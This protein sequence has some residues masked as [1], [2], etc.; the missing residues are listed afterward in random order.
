MLTL[1][2]KHNALMPDQQDDLNNSLKEL[3]ATKTDEEL[4][5]YLIDIKEYS[6]SEVRAALAEQ[7]KR[8]KHYNELQL[9]YLH[10]IIKRKAADESSDTPTYYSQL[11]ILLFSV[12][13]STLYGSILLALNVKNNRDKWIIIGFGLTYSILVITLANTLEL[14]PM[15]PISLNT[16]GGFMLQ[17]LFWDRYLDKDVL[18]KKRS[19][20]FPVLIAIG[21]FMILILLNESLNNS[22]NMGF[23][24]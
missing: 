24:E 22:F 11:A 14:H 1:Y 9:E 13:C 16:I 20:L 3:M 17:T 19:I 6:S 7:Q 10:K 15:M 2:F 4:E 8:G 12:F 21:L 5:N 23:E 18:Y